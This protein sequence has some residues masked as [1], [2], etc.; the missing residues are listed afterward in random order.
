MI[1]CR[2]VGMSAKYARCQYA[3]R[4]WII[5]VSSCLAF[6]VGERPTVQR[7]A[8]CIDNLHKLTPQSLDHYAAIGI[9]MLTL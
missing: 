3:Q 9:L 6:G 4:I 8:T 7:V 1:D 5:N 2:V